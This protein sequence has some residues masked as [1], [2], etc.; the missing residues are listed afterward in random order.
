MAA[1]GRRPAAFAVRGDILPASR[2]PAVDAVTAGRV[3]V[4]APVGRQR[5][6]RHAGA[7]GDGAL[8]IEQCAG[9]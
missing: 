8:R 1:R 9:A 7:A 2:H 3:R 5:A 6:P 4:L